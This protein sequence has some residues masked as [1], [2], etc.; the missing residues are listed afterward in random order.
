LCRTPTDASNSSKKSSSWRTMFS[1]YEKPR[2]C[3]FCLVP[4]IQTFTTKALYNDGVQLR[5]QLNN[6][7]H[8]V[9]SLV[10]HI[11]SSEG[12]LFAA[13][14]IRDLMHSTYL[15]DDGTE[16]GMKRKRFT[17]DTSVLATMNV[18]PVNVRPCHPN[19]DTHLPS[20]N[21]TAHW[22]SLPQ[23]PRSHQV[24][25]TKCSAKQKLCFPNEVSNCAKKKF[26]TSFVGLLQLACVQGGAWTALAA[27]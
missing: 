20:C 21:R 18:L 8:I 10:Q 27:A 1:K 2:Q 22:P 16:T 14:W 4:L 23:R 7:Q 17:M 15:A 24:P 9:N 13:P 3:F 12:T 11:S 5:I 25:K 19:M 6:L 26:F